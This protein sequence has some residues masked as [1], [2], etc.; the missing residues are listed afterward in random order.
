VNV[1]IGKGFE[2]GGRGLFPLIISACM[3]TSSHSVAAILQKKILSRVWRLRIQ[4]REILYCI[5]Y[6]ILILFR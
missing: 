3:I 4:Q 2:D 6:F 5:L 1:S